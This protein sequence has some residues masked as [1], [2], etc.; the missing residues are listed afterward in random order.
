MAAYIGIS[1]INGKSGPNQTPIGA[2]S[3]NLRKIPAE[4]RGNAADR[5]DP[6]RTHLNRILR[7]PDTPAAVVSFMDQL[8]V[9]AGA[10]IKR[11]DQI[12]LF[13]V[14]VDP[15]KQIDDM[16]GFFETSICWMENWF[17]CPLVSAITHY[18][19]ED[20]HMHLLFVPLRGHLLQG[21]MIM[22]GPNKLKQMHKAFQEQ[23]GK[24]Y[25]LPTKSHFSAKE[26]EAGARAVVNQLQQSLPPGWLAADK[27]FQLRKA[28]TGPNFEGVM[29]A[30]NV[31]IDNLAGSITKT[32]STAIAVKTVIKKQTA[33][34]V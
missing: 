3:H 15:K 9:D 8:I 32:A 29:S 27:I 23:V 1:A 34:I 7:G 24:L 18:D 30:F 28:I 25:G 17:N 6:R 26:R 12:K 11:K 14:L 19:E 16:A 10:R 20:P 2:A 33:F 5:I 22:G 31:D 21:W 13:E 4:M